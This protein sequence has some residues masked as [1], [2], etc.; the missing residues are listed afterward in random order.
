MHDGMQFDPIQGQG[1]KPLKVGNPFIFKGYLLR[2]STMIPGNLFILGQKVKGQGRASHKKNA[3][4][5]LCAVGIAGRVFLRFEYS[6]DTGS[7]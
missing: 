4:V 2:H 6:I 3:G 5:G 1:H 7:A